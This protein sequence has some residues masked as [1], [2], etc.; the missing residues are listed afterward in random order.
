MWERTAQ[1][2]VSLFS[3][4]IRIFFVYADMPPELCPHEKEII[5]YLPVFRRRS[6]LPQ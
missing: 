5:S 3:A 4:D 1:T 2:S 6:V